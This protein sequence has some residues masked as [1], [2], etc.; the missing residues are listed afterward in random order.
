RLGT[1][2]QADADAGADEASDRVR[3]LAVARPQGEP[4]L[5]GDLLAPLRHE[6]RLEGAEATGEPQDLRARA[7][8]EI[9]Q[10]A[11]ALAQRAH[12]RVLNVTAVLAQMHGD[13]VRA[14]ALRRPGGA[15]RLG[16]R[17]LAR[18]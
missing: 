7:Q 9:Q 14:A 12:V 5:G 13:A 1:D 11:H 10:R 4:A 15:H 17:G 16:P 6:R 3:E 2:E 8:L 18:L